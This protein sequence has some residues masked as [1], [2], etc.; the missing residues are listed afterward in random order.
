MR[1]PKRGA[2]LHYLFESGR[3]QCVPQQPGALA[4]AHWN[5]RSGELITFIGGVSRPQTTETRNERQAS[6]R[7]LKQGLRVT[8]LESPEGVVQPASLEQLAMGPALGNF[9]VVEHQ[10]HVG[11]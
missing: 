7:T 8:R 6:P 3:H 2:S 1:W 10:N 11:I 5:G 9:A 4:G